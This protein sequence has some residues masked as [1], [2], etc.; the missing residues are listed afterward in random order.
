MYNT[1]G[2]DGNGE[3]SGRKE[4][5]YYSSSNVQKLTQPPVLLCHSPQASAQ[6]TDPQKMS[7]GQKRGE[8]AGVKGYRVG[9]GGVLSKILLKVLKIIPHPQ[10]LSIDTVNQSLVA[11]L[12]KARLCYG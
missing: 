12:R 4:L 3:I 5:C 8:Q 11:L 10:K 1:E 9:R 7:S 2:F 6:R